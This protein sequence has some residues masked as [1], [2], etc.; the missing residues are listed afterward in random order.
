MR[1][2]RTFAV[3]ARHSRARFGFALLAGCWFC[4]AATFPTALAQTAAQLISARAPSLPLPAG[5]NGDSINPQI[6]PDGRFVLFDR[7]CVQSDTGH[8]KP[9]VLSSVP[10]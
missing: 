1:A 4:L 5:G 8:R 2:K 9:V 6:S 3:T 10:L 7:Y